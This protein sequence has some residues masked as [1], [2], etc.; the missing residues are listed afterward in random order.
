MNP[1]AVL[2]PLIVVAVVFVVYCL[3]DLARAEEV[4]GLPR[5]A[6]AII[7]LEAI[8]GLFYLAF[9]RVRSGHEY[10][11]GRQ[12][13][14]A[15]MSKAGELIW[16]LLGDPAAAGFDL[17]SW[18]ES[19]R[20]ALRGAAADSGTLSLPAWF[21]PVA[22]DLGTLL[23]PVGYDRWSFTPT[24]PFIRGYQAGLREAHESALPADGP[25]GGTG[26]R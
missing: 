17:R 21:A 9:G 18:A 5:W 16:P 11:R 7:C 26:A 4:R 8:G 22:D 15:T 23:D 12:A 13:A 14:V 25:A 1:A 24:T 6:W 20:A 19:Q 2:I 3:I 10:E